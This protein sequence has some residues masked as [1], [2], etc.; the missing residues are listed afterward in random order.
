MRTVVVAGTGLAGLRAAQELRAQ[1][2][3]GRLVLVGAE[4]HRPYD[5]PPLSKDF[6][7]GRAVD[8]ELA[9]PE[10]LLDLNAHWHLGE[11]AERFH[12]GVLTLS[13]GA[14]IAADGLVVATGGVPRTL[15]GAREGVHTLRTLDDALA[16]R[17]ALEDAARVVVIGAGFLGAE[18]A[19]TCRAL[20]RDVTVVEAAPVPLAG[21]LGERMGRACARLH[22]EHGVRLLTGAGVAELLG[23][24]RVT[25]VRLTDGREL[26]AEVVVVAVGIRPDCEWLS[27]SGIVADD[28]VLCD[29]GC[30]TA[31]PRVVAVGDV[32]R[33]RDGRR[34]EH[35]TSA[36]E[37]PRVAARN[38]LAGATIEHHTRPGYFWS[39]QYGHR[40]QFAGT[41]N[42][43]DAVRVVEGDVSEAKFVATY[44]RSG[45]V[46]GVLAIDSPRP[47][48]RIRRG[49]TA[50]AMV[51][52]G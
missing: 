21:V 20:G 14:E 34:G 41:A 32:A 5:R 31:N 48:T 13:G 19:S 36:A 16:L 44:T 50:P 25:G 29:S 37:Q 24:P 10:E 2:F 47:F 1:G 46:T 51:H 42:G 27:G 23:R 17:R 6:L 12:D 15:P 49:L 39:D 18:V 8:L 38:L 22:A 4:A 43:C 35:W 7:L 33:R 45:T 30:A 3:D 28:G 11:R 40:I 26:P 52:P 9:S